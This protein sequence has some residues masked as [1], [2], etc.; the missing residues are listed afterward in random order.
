MNMLK[1]RVAVSHGNHLPAPAAGLRLR[2]S[3]GVQDRKRIKKRDGYLCQ[4]CR[5]AGRVTLATQVDHIAPLHLGGSDTAI[6][7]ESICDA[8]HATKTAR[9]TRAMGGANG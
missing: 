1:P 2:G 5:R 7:K 3:A 8:C 9:E 4:T 6:N